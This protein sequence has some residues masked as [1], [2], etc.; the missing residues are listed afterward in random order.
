[1]ANINDD[2]SEEQQYFERVAKTNNIISPLSNGLN[3]DLSAGQM[4]S[5][6][7][8]PVGSYYNPVLDDLQ[9]DLFWSMYCYRFGVKE[10]PPEGRETNRE[11][12]D[13][14]LSDPGFD[15][16]RFVTIGRQVSAAA[17]A[18]KLVEELMKN[19]N[20]KSGM[21]QMGKAEEMED[22]ADDLENQANDQDGEG[23]E[24]D[25]DQ[26]GENDNP[27]D[28]EG[29]GDNEGQ[30]Q[31]G[32][33]DQ[34]GDGQSDSESEDGDGQSD[35]DS[36]DQDDGG[37]GNGQGQG[38]GE[39]ESDGQSQSNN[40]QRKPSS[41]N[42]QGKGRGNGQSQ[43]QGMP[44]NQ[45]SM[46]PEQMRKKA[47]QLR[48]Q[49]EK[50]RER[51][52]EQ[53]DKALQGKLASM[54]RSGSIEKANQFA[55]EVGTFLSS[56][57]LEQGEGVEI[58]LDE[59]RAIMKLMTQKGL[60]QLTQLMGR[61]HG[62]AVDVLKGHAPM[63]I[64]VDSYGYTK[65]IHDIAVDQ[66]AMLGEDVPEEVRNQYILEY[67]QHGLTGF[68]R[69]SQ[70]VQE[71]AFLWGIDSSGSMSSRMQVEPDSNEVVQRLVIANALAL[72]V[73]KAA[74][75]NG[76][77]FNIVVFGSTG[78]ISK[79]VTEK[80]SLAELLRFV[81]AGFGGGTDFDHAL[82]NRMDVFDQLDEQDKF[83]ADIG[84][85]TDGE[86]G[87]SEATKWRLQDLKEMYGV[88]FHVLLVDDA[89][90][91]DI[92]EVADNLMVFTSLTGIAETMA[93]AMWAKK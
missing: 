64:V 89:S 60:A 58:S 78:E 13:W 42:S 20:M 82:N 81:S 29:D 62:V 85:V 49:A 86:A 79:P 76:Q 70:A 9:R 46:T 61:V 30:G 54:T 47:D 44:D 83:S 31:Q 87:I 2:S 18:N 11:M 23:G 69:T 71:G 7:N 53:I 35:G 21:N 26:D 65:D 52:Q 32:E 3:V 84:L 28:G 75:E 6:Q 38:D 80:S 37:Q 88:R 51:G 48:K 1:M 33:G 67:V 10:I 93:H 17:G 36:E 74:K 59:L 12:L 39:D 40:Q 25:Q 27:Q 72:G 45:N 57:G 41:S 73:A 91:N 22:Q 34:D 19:Q 68:T 50:M 5:G 55:D 90:Y 92:L 77:A 15:Q 4:V 56:W 8:A 43:G 24:N 14:L 63:E 16:R 66:L